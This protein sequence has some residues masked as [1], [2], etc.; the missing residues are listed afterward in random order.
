MNVASRTAAVFLLT[1]P[2]LVLGAGGA[3]AHGGHDEQPGRSLPRVLGIEPAVPGLS[4]VVVEGGVRMRIDNGT[5]RPVLVIPAAGADAPVVPPIAPGTSTAWADPR[6]LHA[7]DTAP[8]H[9]ATWAV[10]VVVGDQPATIV[11]DH[12]SPDPPAPLP[13]WCLTIA[14]ALG[15]LSLGYTAAERGPASTAARAVAP[16]AALVVG[17]HLVHV[18]GSAL[19]LAQPPSAVLVLTA[20]GLGALGWLLGPPGVWAAATRRAWGLPTCGAAGAV[21][22]LVTIFDTTGFHR[23]VLA[24]AWSFDLDRTLTV[25]TVGGGV[26]LFLTGCAV[27]NA[28]SAATA[29]HRPSRP[30]R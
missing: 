1:L 27:L 22:A 17:A 6:I 29:G 16:V 10:P 2:L 24:F 3:A 8:D 12:V 26:G 19:V 28:T 4:V 13:W 30:G 23:P 9:P 5:D 15:T 18:L 11:G 25:I 7:P 14:A 20:A 21:A